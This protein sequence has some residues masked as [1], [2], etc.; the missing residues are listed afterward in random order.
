MTSD[1]TTGPAIIKHE[2]CWPVVASRSSSP[3]AEKEAL[4]NTNS[5]LLLLGFLVYQWATFWLTKMCALP[6]Q[7]FVQDSPSPWGS[8]AIFPLYTKPSCL[9]QGWLD[10]G[11]S[12]QKVTAFPQIKLAVGHISCCWIS[13]IF[14]VL[15]TSIP[16][17]IEIDALGRPIP[18]AR[19]GGECPL[20]LHNVSLLLPLTRERTWNSNSESLTR[21]QDHMS[22]GSVIA[23]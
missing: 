3:R 7:C 14:C 21:Q 19:G 17:V 18:I 8:N 6:Q 16:G 1:Q 2:R 12:A 22:N 23:S 4:N 20:W 9:K 13:V 15:Y 11:I 10:T 5:L